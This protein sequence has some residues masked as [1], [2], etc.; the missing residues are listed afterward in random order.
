M[1]LFVHGPFSEVL[2]C[3]L[4][5]CLVRR[6]VVSVSIA[7]NAAKWTWCESQSEYHPEAV[8]RA[9]AQACAWVGWHE[10]GVGRAEQADKKGL[11]LW[12]YGFEYGFQWSKLQWVR[13]DFS[14]VVSC[15]WAGDHTLTVVYIWHM[16]M[17]SRLGLLMGSFQPRGV[18]ESQW[19]SL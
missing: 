18:V 19:S 13:I 7:L 8:W 5:A 4:L 15:N 10:N 1:W 12:R 16:P 14:E 9:E 17:T 11:K 6:Q 3:F 2:N